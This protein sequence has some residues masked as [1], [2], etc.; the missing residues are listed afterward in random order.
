MVK[1]IIT[2]YVDED[3]LGMETS[4]SIPTKEALLNLLNKQFPCLDDVEI[5]QERVIT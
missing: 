1:I 5:K 4:K 2:A 3:F